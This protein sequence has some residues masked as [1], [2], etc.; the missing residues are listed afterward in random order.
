MQAEA[1]PV[2]GQGD[3][4]LRMNDVGPFAEMC[5]RPNPR[6]LVFVFVPSLLATLWRAEGH[7][8]ADLTAEEVARIRD[9]ANGF[10]TVPLAARAAEKRRGYPDLDPAVA[11][12]EW[13]RRRPR[14]D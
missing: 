1:I 3:G 9:E 5:R 10:V 11:Y 13:R 12:E 4:P 6:R 7:K 8:G 14:R 2:V